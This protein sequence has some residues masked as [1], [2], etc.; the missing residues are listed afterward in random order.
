MDSM[1]ARPVRGST[2]LRCALAIVV[3][4][5]ATIAGAFTF[6]AFGIKPCELCLKERLPY[7]VAIALAAVTFLAAWRAW[8]GATRIGFALLALV[9]LA[10]AG[11]GVY[12]AGVEWAFWPGPA[13]C[14]GPLDRAPSNQDF[15]KQLQT[16]RAV[17]CD[18]VAI[19]IAGLSLAGWNAVISLALAAVALVG[20]TRSGRTRT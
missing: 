11:L 6:E 5:N 16:F 2:A 18:A 1:V 7:Y 3:L 12:H 8:A 17:R 10:S 13:D 14:S 15:L 4:A 19:R 20:I 9:F